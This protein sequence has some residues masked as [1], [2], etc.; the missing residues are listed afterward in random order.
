MLKGSLGCP[1]T[2]FTHKSLRPC[3]F[4]RRKLADKGLIFR[5]QFVRKL[6]QIAVEHRAAVVALGGVLKRRLGRFARADARRKFL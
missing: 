5:R 1:Q 6:L 2:M 4:C 3:R